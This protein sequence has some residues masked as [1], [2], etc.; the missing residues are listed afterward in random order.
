MPTK[1]VPMIFE[2]FLPW[3]SEH[4]QKISIEWSKTSLPN[5]QE[6][7]QPFNSGYSQDNSHRGSI[8]S[9]YGNSSRGRSHSPIPVTTQP[10]SP[11][12]YLPAPGDITHGM[13]YIGISGYF[14]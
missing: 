11:R 5:H 13:V 8:H 3:S 2:T 6:Q 14:E 9:I 4:P 12:P 10:V 1:G 7:Y